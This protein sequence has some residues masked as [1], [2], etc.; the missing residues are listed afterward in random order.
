[1]TVVE[2]PPKENVFAGGAADAGALDVPNWK[3]DADFET[4]G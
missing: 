1:M 3:S 2:L 4:S